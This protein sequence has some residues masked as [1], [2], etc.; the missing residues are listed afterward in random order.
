MILLLDIGNT[1]V[2]LGLFRAGSLVATR[3]AATD[4][5]GTADEFEATLDGQLGAGRA[6]GAGAA[7]K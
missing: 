6:D 1:N 7:D 3:R 4:P 5:R 2:T